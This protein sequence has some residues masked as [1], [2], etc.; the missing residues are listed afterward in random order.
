MSNV[1]AVAKAVAWNTVTGI[2][3]RVVG[4]VGTLVL[5]R[6]ISPDEYGQVST[7]SICVL[8]ATMFA[9]LQLGQYL[10]ARGY[11][12]GGASFHAAAI[13]VTLGLSAIGVV[14]LFRH[15]LGP[16]LGAPDMARFVPGFALASAM[17]V[18]SV[19]PEKT[20]ARDLRFR[21][22]ALTRG[23]GEVLYTAVALSFAPA[24]GGMAI[25]F[26][27]IGRSLFVLAVFLSSADKGWMQP[28]RFSRDTTGSMLR[29]S[30][31]LA[32]KA[33]TDFAS[34]RWDNLMISRYH[35]AG[36]MGAY[37]L[38]Y[39]L[40]LSS[41]LA[42]AEHVADVL[43]PSFS[44]LEK[45]HRGP[46]L[47]RALSAIALVGFPF[48][49]GLA[50]TAHAVVATFLPAKW[51]LIAPM[52]I[53]L[54][55]QAAVAPVG[56]TLRAFHKAEERT[57][58]VMVTG[59]V[60]LVALLG[61][62]ATLG[63]LGPLWACAAVDLAFLGSVAM[64]WSGMRRDYRPWIWPSVRGVS[65][66]LFACVPLVAAVLIVQALERQWGLASPILA[67][68]VEIPAGVVGYA[69]GAALFAR[70]TSMDLIRLA[71][72]VI[73]YGRRREAAAGART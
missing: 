50:A 21:L 52:L 42:V 69:V 24:W 57:A 55:P 19:V 46:A 66:A 22:I 26:G 15:P 65:G 31:P 44:R 8:T 1:T 35:G 5:A 29:Y 14:L 60:K 70:E 2:G 27:N 13:H 56:W 6:F 11:K 4:L 64:L 48:A 28:C 36:V 12:Q 39:N 30:L 40:G 63:R 23:I 59:P 54:S 61:L 32:I 45:R 25:V 47:V 20:L 37:N 71:G 73:G 34:G 10:I 17:D 41:T 9:N 38:A 18:F 62:L 51:A 43:F 33:V 72:A 67:L 49:A 7:A 58:F 3:S 68:C 53:A 16:A